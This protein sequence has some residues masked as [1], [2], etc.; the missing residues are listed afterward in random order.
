MDIDVSELY[1][2]YRKLILNLMRAIIEELKN[3]K[4]LEAV[5]MDNTD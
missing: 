4:M 3:T 1:D 2:I 5:G